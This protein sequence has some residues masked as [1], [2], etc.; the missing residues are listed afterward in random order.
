MTGQYD[1]IFIAAGVN[2]LSNFKGKRKI[3]PKFVNFGDLV[4]DMLKKTNHSSPKK[5][6]PVQ[7]LILLA[8]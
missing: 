6:H 8:K 7:S 5:N 3:E 4:R 1:L 2:S